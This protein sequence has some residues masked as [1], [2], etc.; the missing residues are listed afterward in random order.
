MKLYIAEANANLAI[1][2]VWANH[3]DS[4]KRVVLSGLNELEDFIVS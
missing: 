4:A 3:C 1:G 2:A